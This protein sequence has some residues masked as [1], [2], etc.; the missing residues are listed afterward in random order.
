MIVIHIEEISEH[1]LTDCLKKMQQIKYKI[2]LI[3]Y[4]TGYMLPDTSMPINQGSGHHT[5]TAIYKPF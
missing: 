3:L 2:K 5:F 1:K 4:I